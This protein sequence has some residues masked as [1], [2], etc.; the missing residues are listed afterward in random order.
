MK[1]IL[2]ILLAVLMLAALSVTAFATNY[3]EGE[4]Y[5][6]TLPSLS[7]AD[8]TKSVYASS[9]TDHSTALDNTAHYYFTVAWTESNA[10]VYNGGITTYIWNAEEAKYVP[11][12]TRTEVGRGWSG[13][14]T[15][16]ITITNQSNA[17]IWSSE[18]FAC[19]AAYTGGFTQ[20]LT[21]DPVQEMTSAATSVETNY[22]DG[23]A[24][25]PTTATYTAVISPAANYKEAITNTSTAV[26]T[27]TLSVSSTNPNP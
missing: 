18:S 8:A 12:T 13:N 19:T 2:S 25:V 14:A 22:A 7:A 24:G 4:P 26:G 5:N 10:L 20:T 23:T 1:K 11:D 3:T 15:Y 6:E 27:I 9:V 21:G 17:S 16:G